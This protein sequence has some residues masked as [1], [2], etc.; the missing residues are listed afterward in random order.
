MS[1]VT[2]QLL[3]TL[4]H[5]IFNNFDIFLLLLYIVLRS[6]LKLF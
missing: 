6:I 2:P 5:S 4:L 1:E 3:R